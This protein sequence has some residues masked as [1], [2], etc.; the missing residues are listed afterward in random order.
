MQV[1]NIHR[2]VAVP[3]TRIQREAQTMGHLG[4]R[5]RIVTVFYLGQ[6]QNHSYRVIELMGG[7]DV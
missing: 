7:G 6:R 3:R 2:P 4:S 1:I 5:L